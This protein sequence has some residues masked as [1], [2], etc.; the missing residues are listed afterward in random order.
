MIPNVP[1][2]PAA[3]GPPAGPVSGTD[4][5]RPAEAFPQV[6]PQ[7]AEAAAPHGPDA[8]GSGGV[9]AEVNKPFA[10]LDRLEQDVVQRLEALQSPPDVTDV[11]SMR[12]EMT[13]M[14]LVQMRVSRAALAVQLSAKAVEMTTAGINTLA[15]TQT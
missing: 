11:A 13:Q 7:P 4:A 8:V 12:R 5:T 9:L 3:A 10:E 14:L 6:G 2:V 15:R 1:N